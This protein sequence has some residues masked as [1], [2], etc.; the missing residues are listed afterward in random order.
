MHAAVD[1]GKKGVGCAAT[2][3]NSLPKVLT[4]VTV[5]RKRTQD[6]EAAYAPSRPVAA[7][8]RRGAGPCARALRECAG[9]A[10]RQSPRPYRS[11]LVRDRRA[12]VERDRIAARAR[13]LSLP[14]ALQPGCA[15]RPDRRCRPLGTLAGRSARRLAAVR[16]ALPSVPRHAVAD[17][18]RPCLRR[19]VRH[20]VR[21]R[22]GDRRSLLRPDRRGAGDSRL[23][24]ARAFRPV[25][26]RAAGDDRRRP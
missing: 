8:R 12:L 1:A 13:S 24:A 4:P 10:D 2:R 23:P 22:D 7:R 19:G 21:A 26:H 6:V 14:D 5:R 25:R 11:G 18:A 3:L 17:L 9:P 20:R 16:F 15:A